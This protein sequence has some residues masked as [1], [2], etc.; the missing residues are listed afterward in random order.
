LT[1]SRRIGT[2]RESGKSD[3]HRGVTN[4]NRTIAVVIALGLVAGGATAAQ[5]VT[6]KVS[7]PGGPVVSI[8][9]GTCKASG[10]STGVDDAV[11]VTKMKSGAMCDFVRVRVHYSL[12]SWSG[13]SNWTTDP[14]WAVRS[15]PGGS[16]FNN[17][18]HGADSW[19]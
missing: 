6:H 14:E 10:Y 1:A 12:Y 13:Y 3:H 2:F 15:A 16:W 7:Y 5:A 8:T 4:V 9:D 17:S 18:Q 19:H 11:G